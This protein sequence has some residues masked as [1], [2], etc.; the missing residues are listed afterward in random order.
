MRDAEDPGCEPRRI[1]E[2]FQI[3]VGLQKGILTE[4]EGVLAAVDEPEE[5]IED[6]PVPA[7]DEEVERINIATP[8]LVDQVGVFNRPKDQS[9]APGK[10]DGSKGKKDG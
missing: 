5:V 10:E 4:V 3:L 9:L 1:F 8:R 2:F 6:T 7:G